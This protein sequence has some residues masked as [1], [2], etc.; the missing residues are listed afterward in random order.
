M[1]AVTHPAPLVPDNG[2]RWDTG[3]AG[4]CPELTSQHAACSPCWTPTTDTPEDR[5]TQ[6]NQDIGLK[7]GGAA[8]VKGA[9]PES[10]RPRQVQVAQ[11]LGPLPLSW[12][13]GW[14]VHLPRGT[15]LP[16][17]LPLEMSYVYETNVMIQ[18]M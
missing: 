17:P 10:G 18:E 12:Q 1:T 6:K 9:A 15:Q 2:G 13:R 14:T 5:I 16:C 11:C 3:A 4:K 8:K 7:L